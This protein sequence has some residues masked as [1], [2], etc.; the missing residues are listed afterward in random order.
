MLTFFS[1]KMMSMN[2]HEWCYDDITHIP[3]WWC[4]RTCCI[5]RNDKGLVTSFDM[6][7]EMTDI[8]QWIWRCWHDLTCSDDMMV[9]W[10]VVINLFVCVWFLLTYWSYNGS[11]NYMPLYLLICFI[12]WLWRWYDYLVVERDYMHWYVECVFWCDAMMSCTTTWWHN[13]VVMN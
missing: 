4:I 6:V 7:S 13:Y 1:Y 9:W 10:N 2:L 12:K 11:W 3:A 8:V 5:S